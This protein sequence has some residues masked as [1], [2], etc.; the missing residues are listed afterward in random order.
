[1][2]DLGTPVTPHQLAHPGVAVRRDMGQVRYIPGNGCIL[3]PENRS[4]WVSPASPVVVA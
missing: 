4:R 1:M 3:G 2:S